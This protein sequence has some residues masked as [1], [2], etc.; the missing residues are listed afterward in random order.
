MDI[1]DSLIDLQ[2]FNTLHI[3]HVPS[4]NFTAAQLNAI[5]LQLIVSMCRIRDELLA[6]IDRSTRFAAARYLC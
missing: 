6:T 3:Y 4:F 1:Q 2:P 5:Q